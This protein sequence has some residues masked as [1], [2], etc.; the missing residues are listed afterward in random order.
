MVES[1]YPAEFYRGIAK[2]EFISDDGIVLISAFQFDEQARLDGYKELSINW[3]DDSRSMQIL[4]NQK[5]ENGNYQFQAGVATLE[6]SAI[7][8]LLFRFLENKSFSYE[9]RVIQNNPYHGNLL[10]SASLSKQKRMMILNNLAILASNNRVV[11][12][13]NC[14]GNN[15]ET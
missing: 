4:L 14:A 3:N 11:V 8:Q 10:L 2:K 7:K 12:N 9:R 15:T 6:L 5:K 13:D 1:E